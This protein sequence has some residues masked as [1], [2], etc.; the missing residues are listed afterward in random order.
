[1]LAAQE[2]PMLWLLLTA[3]AADAAPL[4]INGANAQHD[5]V[6]EAGQEVLV[7]GS[8][9]RINLKGSCGKITVRG[10]NNRISV[11]GLSHAVIEGS[12]NDLTYRRNLSDA[13]TLP[14]RKIGTRNKI[15]HA[16]D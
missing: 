7:Q 1:M 3:Q 5:L 10:S 6:C 13:D 15:A 14:T 8:R 11:D 9:L 2:E 16:Q 12:A 4:V